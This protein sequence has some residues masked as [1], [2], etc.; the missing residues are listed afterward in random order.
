MPVLASQ[1]RAA[2]K[3]SLRKQGYVLGSDGTLIPRD[4]EVTKETLRNL[5][6]L[7]VEHRLATAEPNLQRHEERLLSFIADGTEVDPR[8]IKPRLVLV[9]PSSVNELLFRYVSLHW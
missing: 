5:N 4:P 7:A 9:L 1:L 6:R 3:R 2:I 8:N